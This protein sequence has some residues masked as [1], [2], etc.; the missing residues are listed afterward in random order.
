[1]CSSD[2]L[3]NSLHVIFPHSGH[4]AE[5]PCADG[6]V[7]RF[8]ERASVKG[9][10]VA[11]AAKTPPPHFIVKVP[12]EVRVPPR[13]LDA[14]V[15]SYALPGFVMALARS[16]DHLVAKSPGSAD[17]ELFAD[18]DDHFF[19]KSA[20]LEVKVLRNAA[21]AVVAVVVKSGDQ[22][23]RGRRQP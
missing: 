22:E 3:P 11:C 8:V 13:L 18:A 4:G 14:Y 17:L 9:L 5:G 6:I 19:A 23:F 7:A 1:M 2:L 20:D 21:G 10:D 12:V 16:G 15:G